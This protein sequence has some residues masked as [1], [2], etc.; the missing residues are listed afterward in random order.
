[1]SRP[2]IAVMLSLVVILIYISFRFKFTFAIGAVAALFHDVLITL[3]LFI[4][5]ATIGILSLSCDAE[6]C[7]ICSM[8]LAELIGIAFFIFMIR[9]SFFFLFQVLFQDPLA[10]PFRAF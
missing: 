8:V 1:M 6:D 4:L 10:F 2:V 5:I 3:G 9:N 7:G